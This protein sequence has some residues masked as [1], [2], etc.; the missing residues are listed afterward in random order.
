ML[1]NSKIITIE[2]LIGAGKSSLLRKIKLKFSNEYILFAKES[3]ELFQTFQTVNG[4][5]L[6]PLE[7]YY[8]DQK[9]NTTRFQFHVLDSYETA[10]ENK[11]ITPHW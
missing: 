8:Q 7:M 9:M 3:L 10:L 11:P 4:T 2:V 6:N 5:R 1:T